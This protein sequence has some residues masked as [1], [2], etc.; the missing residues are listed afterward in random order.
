MNDKNI[1]NNSLM[2][3]IERG[4]LKKLQ[5]LLKKG[6]DVNTRNDDSKET[7]LMRAA[8]LGHEEIVRLLCDHKADLNARDWQHCTAL[9]WAIVYDREKIVELL[10]GKGAA[11]DTGEARTRTALM[12]ASTYGH[13]NIARM[14]LEAG[15]D[16]EAEDANGHTALTLAQKSGNADVA[17]LLKGPKIAASSLQEAPAEEQI[18]NNSPK[19]AFQEMP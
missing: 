2:K 19:A 9:I 12:W 13:L 7:P 10:L 6:V 14:L 16:L 4:D 8:Q 1:P 17:D 11:T 5:S 15:A 18:I 3:V